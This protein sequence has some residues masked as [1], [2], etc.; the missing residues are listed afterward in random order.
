MTTRLL[1]FVIWAAVAASAVFWVNRFMASAT[2]VPAHA[3]TLGAEPVSTA[4]L[5]RLFG[6]PPQAV[7]EAPPPTAQESRFKLLG[8]VAPKAGRRSGWAL[9]AVDDKPARSFP[10]GGSVDT[11]LV[12][13]AISHRQVDLGPAGGAVALSLKLPAVAEATRGTPGA[14][15]MAPG[16]PGM[17]GAPAAGAPLPAFGAAA[18]P[19]QP[20]AAMVRPNNLGALARQRLSPA[21][22]GGVVRQGFQ[23]QPQ[24]Q[25][26][27][28]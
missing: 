21:P 16:A 25:Q 2:P 6:A 12:V 17:P 28:Q 7:A 8:V 4:A 15:A 13:Q 14:A 18:A 10:L 20:G 3:V 26:P 9:L 27:Q 23:Q 5:T 22:P 24:Q 11:G 19:A 1:S